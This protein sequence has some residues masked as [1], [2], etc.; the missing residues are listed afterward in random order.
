MFSTFIGELRGYFGKAFVLAV[1]LPVFVFASL[2]LVVYLLGS[3]SLEVVWQH[4]RSLQL[5]EQIVLAIAFLAPVTLFAFVI[6]YLQ[7]PITRLFEG[8]WEGWPGLRALGRWKRERH[9]KQAQTLDERLG[10]LGQEIPALEQGGQSAVSL[11]VEYNRLAQRRLNGFPPPG[12]EK[13]FMPTR[14]GNI[15]K[16]AELYPYHRYVADSVILWPRLRQVI[17]DGFVERMQELKI[18]VDFLLLFSL[19]AIL[20]AVWAVPY[21]AWQGTGLLVIAICALGLPVGWLAYRAAL[22]PALAY[23]ELIKVAYDLYRHALLKSLGLNV[24]ATLDQEQKLWGSISDFVVWNLPP[25][26]GEA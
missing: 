1:W 4:W 2:S 20:F 7:V 23:A 10:Q 18:A 8:Y 5:D 22:S 16:A 19:S 12:D 21:L 24:P 9:Q 6:H 25:V 15:Y 13:H 11:R 14:L 3:G 26:E 17:P